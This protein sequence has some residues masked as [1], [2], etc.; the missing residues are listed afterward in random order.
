MDLAQKMDLALAQVGALKMDLA[1]VRALEMNPIGVDVIKMDL[2]KLIT[3][4]N[5]KMTEV[6]AAATRKEVL[7]MRV[8]RAVAAVLVKVGTRIAERHLRRIDLFPDTF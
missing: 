4:V 3:E 1:G 5:L 7:G 2:V 6:M 8:N